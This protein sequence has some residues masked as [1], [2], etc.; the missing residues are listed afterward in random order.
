[1][2]L[3]IPDGIEATCDNEGCSKTEK[4]PIRYI[5]SGFTKST[6]IAKLRKM[7]WYVS[8][9]RNMILCPDCA[10]KMGVRGATKITNAI[11]RQAFSGD[12]DHVT[13]MH[14]NC[15][16]IIDFDSMGN[17]KCLKCG[18]VSKDQNL[19]EMFDKEKELK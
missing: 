14:K 16:G 19:I 1:M 9:K 15:G 4:I 8:I 5:K 6:L 3:N 10:V 13:F 7:A 2:G 17:Y 11:K 18:L 12:P